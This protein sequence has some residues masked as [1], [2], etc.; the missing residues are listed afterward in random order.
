[1]A[2]ATPELRSRATTSLSPTKMQSGLSKPVLRTWSLGE[3]GDSTADASTGRAADRTGGVAHGSHVGFGIGGSDPRVGLQSQPLPGHVV[4]LTGPPLC[5]AH[6][7]SR[8]YCRWRATTG[9]GAR[10]LQ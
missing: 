8:L 6:E 10:R 3:L 5:W 7:R 9:E 4:V 1:M 2:P